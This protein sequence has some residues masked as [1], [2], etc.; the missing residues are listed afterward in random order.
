MVMMKWVVKWRDLANGCAITPD[1][2]NQLI[3]R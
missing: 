2:V 1:M 3:G